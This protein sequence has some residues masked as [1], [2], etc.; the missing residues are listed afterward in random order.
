QEFSY[1]FDDLADVFTI[2][3]G[4]Q[5][6]DARRKNTIERYAHRLT[7]DHVALAH[8]YAGLAHFYFKWGRADEAAGPAER[9]AVVIEKLLGATHPPVQDTEV[10]WF[11]PLLEAWAE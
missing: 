5:A 2:L 9:T 3:D 7:A 10:S 4:H 6:A 1:A 8:H 11:I